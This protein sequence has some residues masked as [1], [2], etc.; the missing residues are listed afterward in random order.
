MA[1]FDMNALSKEDRGFLERITQGRQYTPEDFTYR[2]LPAYHEPA[3]D[4]TKLTST[5][6]GVEFEFSHPIDTGTEKLKLA[7][8]QAWNT[9][10]GN[11]A[12]TEERLADAEKIGKALKIS[13][14]VLANSPEVF[15]MA[16]KEYERQRRLAATQGKPFSPQ[17]IQETYPELTGI[18]SEDPVQAAL[19]LHNY[20]EILSLRGITQEAE[21][22]AN[23]WGILK[24]GFS[25][26]TTGYEMAELGNKLREAEL[27]GEDTTALQAEIKAKSAALMKNDTPESMIGAVLFE[28]ARQAGQYK[29][30]AGTVLYGAALGGSAGAVAGSIAPVVGNVAGAIGGAGIGAKAGLAKFTYDMEGGM[31]YIQERQAGMSVENAAASSRV[32]GAGNAAIEILGLKAFMKLSGLS[33]AFKTAFRKQIGKAAVADVVREAAEIGKSG[34]SVF[35]NRMLRAAIAATPELL[36]ES[37]Q[38]ATGMLVHNAYA[39]GE[40]VEQYSFGDIL[41]ESFDAGL[42]ALP[43]TVGMVLPTAALSSLG[44]AMAVRKI[45]RTEIEE[46]RELYARRNEEHMA[47]RLLAMRPSLKL[48]KSA[49]DLFGKMVQSQTE[50][51]GM[52]TIYIDAANAAETAEGQ[53]ALRSLVDNGL[54]TEAEVQKA[55]ADGTQLTLSSGAYFQSIPDEKVHKAL[56]DH[57]TMNADGRT[58]HELKERAERIASLAKTVREGM[59]QKEEE[60]IQDILDRDFPAF[61]EEKAKADDLGLRTEKDFV[62]D[63][64]RYDA[65]RA[66]AENVLSRGFSHIKENYNAALKEAKE[67]WGDLIDAGKYSMETHGEGTRINYAEGETGQWETHRESLNEAWHQDWYK[68]HGRAPT[69]RETYDI[70]HKA[71]L[72]EIQNT[73]DGTAD[74]EIRGGAEESLR[75]LTVARDEVEA[76]EG[77]K[78][79]FGHLDTKDLLARKT[80]SKEAYEKLYLPAFNALKNAAPAAREA[81]AESALIYARTADVFHETYGTPYEDFARIAVNGRVGEGAYGMPVTSGLSR[82]TQVKI[83]DLA[84]KIPAK[85]L[86]NASIKAYI[87]SLAQKP[88]TTA[89]AKAVMDILPEK[90]DHIVYSSRKGGGKRLFTERQGML[91][92]I[93]DIIANSVLVESGPNNKIAPLTGL[94]GKRRKAQKAKNSV[95][96]YHRFYVPIRDGNDLYTVRIVAEE[97]NGVITVNPA[98][99]KFYD[100]I[101]D[102]RRTPA[103]AIPSN[104]PSVV[105]SSAS[106]NTISLYDML[107]GVKDM[108]GKPY[109]QMAGER[110]A[111]ANHEKLRLAQS[112]EAEGKTPEEIWKETGWL[113]GKDNKWRFEIPDN[114]DAVDFGKF[115]IKWEGIEVEASSVELQDLYDNEALY[116]AYPW[117]RGVQVIR[118]KMDKK[119]VGYV[120]RR[121]GWNSYVIHLNEE[122]TK[123]EPERAKRAMIH[124]LQHIIQSTEGFAVGGNPKSVRSQ[125]QR[126]LTKERKEAEKLFPS[127]NAREYYLANRK[128]MR[129]VSDGDAQAEKRNGRIIEAYEKEGSNAETLGLTND[130]LEKLNKLYE[131]IEKLE[132]R[133]GLDFDISEDFQAYEDLAGEQE[134]RAAESRAEGQK[135]KAA[136]DE[137]LVHYRRERYAEVEAKQDEAGKKLLEKLHGLLKRAAKEEQLSEEEE[138]WLNEQYEHAPAELREVAEDLAIAEGIAEKSKKE[139]AMPRPHDDNAIVVF[140]GKEL[141]YS[142][143]P[144]YQTMGEA[145]EA[146]LAAHE[147]AWQE[148]LAKLPNPGE[149]PKEKIH[150]PFH[151][152]DTPLVFRLIGQNAY[153]HQPQLPIYMD[154]SKIQQLRS[155]HSEMTVAVLG[156]IPRALANP[157]MMLQSATEPGRVVSVLELKGENGVNIVV[158]LELNT[159]KNGVEAN[160]I[161]SAYSKAE[162]GRTDNAWF[163]KQ[164]QEGRLVYVD[165]GRAASVLG[166]SKEKAATLLKDAGVQFPMTSKKRNGISSIRIPDER[167]LVKLREENPSLY[168]GDRHIGAYDPAQNLIALFNG[169]NQSTLVHETAHMWLTM[170]QNVARQGNEKAA[171][172]LETIYGWASFSEDTMKEYEGTTLEKE[173]AGYAELLRKNPQDLQTQERFRQERFAR[174][175]ERYLATG[176]APTKELRGAFGRFKT[177]LGAIYR[178][179]QNL[180]KIDPPEEI[181][182][183]FDAMLATED[184]VEAWAAER[185]LEKID[186]AYDFSKTEKDNIKAWAESVKQTAKEKALKEFSQKYERETREAF[187]KGADA[188]RADI[189]RQLREENPVYEAEAAMESDTSDALKMLVLERKGFRSVEEYKEALAAAGGSMHDRAAQIIDEQRKSVEQTLLSPEAIRAAAEDVLAGP[190]G[191]ARLAQIETNAMRRKLNEHIR[192]IRAAE[193]EL[194]GKKVSAD[195]VKERLGLLSD[196]EKEIRRK[197]RAEKELREDLEKEKEKVKKLREELRARAEGLRRAE[198]GLNI[199]LRSLYAEA[200]T[201]LDQEKVTQAIN[202]KWWER[203]AEEAS[204]HASKATTE[205]RWNEA[206]SAKR[207]QLMYSAMAKV[208]KE[209]EEEIRRTLQGNPK[210]GTPTLTEDGDEKYGVLGMVRRVS[211]AKDPVRMEDNS[212]YFLTHMAYQLGLTKEDGQ[213]PMNE[214]G[215]YLPFNWE[216]FYKLLDTQ[217]ALG[218]EGRSND[219]LVAPWLRV[220][221][222][223]REKTLYTS[224]SMEQFR[225]ATAAMKT[226]YNLGRSEYEPHTWDGKTFDELAAELLNRPVYV[227]RGN[228]QGQEVGKSGLEAVREKLGDIVMEAA[229]ADTLLSRMGER[230]KEIFYDPIDRADRYEQELN[231]E[232]KRG[233]KKTESIYTTKEWAKIRG[234]HVYDIPGALSGMTKENLLVIALNWG[235]Q[236]NR[237]RLLEMWN[238]RPEDAANIENYLALY[239]DEKDWNYVEAVWAHIGSFWERDNAA[240]KRQYGQPLGKVPG[241][242]FKVNGRVIRGAY[243][244]IVY[245][246]KLGKKTSDREINDLLRAQMA[247]GSSFALGM[248]STKTRK[249]GSG[250]QKVYLWLDVYPRHMEEVVHRIAMREAVTDVYKLLTRED[251][252]EAVRQQLGKSGYDLL[253]KWAQDV[254]TP[255]TERLGAMGRVLSRLAKKSGFAIMGYRTMTALLNFSQVSVISAYMGPA[256]AYR[257]LSKF[258][259]SGGRFNVRENW[260][261]VLDHS[262]FMRERSE[263]MDKDLARDIGIPLSRN[264]TKADAMWEENTGWIRDHAFWFIAQTDMLT[265]AAQWKFIYEKTYADAVEKNLTPEAAE[266]MAVAKA[267]KAVSDCYGSSRMKDMTG[268]QKDKFVMNFVPFYSW[269]ATMLNLFIRAGYQAKDGRGTRN[270]V[271]AVLFIWIAQAAMD[272]LARSALNGEDEDKKYK[273]LASSILSGGP[274]Q[275]IPLLRDFIQTSAE[276]ATGQGSYGSGSNII[277]SSV[278]AEAVKTVQAASSNKKDW[279]DVMRGIGRTTNRLI[280]FPDTISDGFWTLVKFLTT[281]TEADFWDLFTAILFDRQ[282][283]K[284]AKK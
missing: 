55:V 140:G 250:G 40:N 133:L 142:A 243:Y 170:L 247:G 52:G 202:W 174:A 68:E 244:P 148:N 161:T 96:Y 145:A 35:G 223:G 13:P 213:P 239:L 189:L 124:E 122:R 176:S 81:A 108:W 230:W 206:A 150:G 246:P 137:G 221:F 62:R 272:S 25:A 42:Q 248:N 144:Y 87:S 191:M 204:R 138:N 76:L 284:E 203:R 232:L 252:T 132:E 262:L 99:V 279:T 29:S 33:S 154:I 135:T 38:Q 249:N 97:S 134:A 102:K 82:N 149:K 194:S 265:S 169:A 113:K 205:G 51:V 240:F 24:N 10:T 109:Y 200:R 276:I 168:Q 120:E 4:D 106:L 224:L 77:L 236:T 157:I 143:E 199:P 65:R 233:W 241:I 118:Q 181:R 72:D 8:G 83:L 216:S 229:R 136:F 253:V 63:R 100:V 17:S 93:T 92:N 271:D 28:T 53:A 48:F 90:A 128:W 278:V 75:Q 2:P 165:R 60:V 98:S 282:L 214:R 188:V 47:D 184:E 110:A 257:A 15:D 44:H 125:I 14:T 228:S 123:S 269:A 258:Y 131:N 59:A 226:A 208:A 280:A 71:K 1:D 173:F 46:A 105:Q 111:T 27:A 101:I 256:D 261:F 222:D 270:L 50:R 219:D 190:E 73:L 210:P 95:R 281:D 267:D 163:R 185:E 156:E 86:A 41:D 115:K 227:R 112:L 255:P 235:T 74:E 45:S 192:Q 238:L 263:N 268:I 167:D 89:D 237:D 171:K 49:P 201:R 275:G 139:R 234:E 215:E 80:L 166:L 277:T 21:A 26:G 5:H 91:L 225:D 127:P 211:R 103:P 182:R 220:L 141:P 198:Q 160:V 22:A 20:E 159:T 121:E 251:V 197:R 151:V 164:V 162:G 7:L 114:L 180:G 217:R 36:E 175:F 64:E 94:R 9:L 146:K 117:L 260:K 39:K 209:N 158:P 18:A 153:G 273:R 57:L 179:L 85:A 56:E 155:D 126:E 119:A 70:A 23:A 78:D 54:T 242:T 266:E 32:T 104:G 88:I 264:A 178:D 207:N 11:N 30:G 79:Y 43:A 147:K 187:E 152:M 231:E 172:D 245:D 84:G 196:E 6:R 259:Y 212:K 274:I 193:L 183:I 130:T 107:K 34:A 69:Q 283:K 66:A 129:A 16:A 67:R 116:A 218:Q 61:D 254:W 177:W 12:P 195:D 19:A 186:A 3:A 37:A 58:M 31:Q